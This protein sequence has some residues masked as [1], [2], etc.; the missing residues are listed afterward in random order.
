MFN[1]KKDKAGF[2]ATIVLATLATVIV[3]A[4]LV[5]L[6]MGISQG[7]WDYYNLPI[8]FILGF[9]WLL[10]VATVLTRVGIFRMQ[11]LKKRQANG[12]K[13]QHGELEESSP[14]GQSAAP[15]Q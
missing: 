10:L 4:S 13:N 1:Y 2:Y 7:Q 3:A 11:M 6:F 15:H 9:G 14:H 5:L 12:L 8:R